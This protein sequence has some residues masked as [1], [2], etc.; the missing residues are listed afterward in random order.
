MFFFV[1][2]FVVIERFGEVK[3]NGVVLKDV[4]EELKAKSPKQKA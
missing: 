4:K 2:L 3:F 1:L